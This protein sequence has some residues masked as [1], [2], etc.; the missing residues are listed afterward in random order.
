[1]QEIAEVEEDQEVDLMIIN[2]ETITEIIEEVT[3]EIKEI[4]VI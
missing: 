1:L 2:K 4:K 3:Q